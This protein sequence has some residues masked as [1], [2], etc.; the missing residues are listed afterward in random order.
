LSEHLARIG[1]TRYVCR[2]SVGIPVGKWPC[3][4]TRRRWEGNSMVDLREVFVTVGDGGSGLCPEASLIP[5]DSA[6]IYRK[7]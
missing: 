6:V 5:L 4:R 1:D 7:R 3:R 2:I